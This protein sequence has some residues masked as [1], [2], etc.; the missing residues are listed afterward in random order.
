MRPSEALSKIQ[1]SVREKVL[2][3]DAIVRDLFL[4]LV[5]GGAALIK[6]PPGTAKQTVLRSF[7]RA[8][9]VDSGMISCTPDLLPS[10]FIGGEIMEKDDEGHT[11]LS[12]IKGPVFTNFLIVA[13]LQQLPT[14]SQSALLEAL[15]DGKVT[16]AGK[17]HAL[18][19]PFFLAA[20]ITTQDEKVRYDL[21]SALLDRFYIQIETSTPRLATESML[22][23]IAS[24]GAG[25]NRSASDDD[26]VFARIPEFREGARSVAVPES[27]Y[28]AAVNAVRKLRLTPDEFVGPSPRAA[29]HW[30]A[31]SKARAFVEGR[32]SI[33]VDDLM[34]TS[35]TVL[36]HRCFGRRS[37][38]T[39]ADLVG[40]I[41]EAFAKI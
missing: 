19:Q 27:V 24:V 34:A 26:N 21:G 18:P 31:F 41:D 11:A 33:A 17:P 37:M 7:A 16:S 14:K 28:L 15:E 5:A 10:D 36:P 22:C 9:G 12:F 20:T 6:G 2:D 25:D 30:L 32:A 1:R 8:L 4:T 3:S 29:T 38:L 13:H 40:A 39:E 35:R 23:Q